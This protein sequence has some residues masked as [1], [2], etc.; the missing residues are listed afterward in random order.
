MV[1]PPVLVMV[2]TCLHVSMTCLHAK[3]TLQ[4]ELF[5]SLTQTNFRVLLVLANRV[6]FVSSDFFLII[7]MKRQDAYFEKVS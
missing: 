5:T 6:M 3:Y 7:S 1:C 2:E 4:W